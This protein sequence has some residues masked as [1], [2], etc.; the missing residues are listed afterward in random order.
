MYIR[1][2]RVADAAAIARVHV[3][4]WRTTYKDL[5]PED[6][7]ANLSYEQRERF[8]Q[9]IVSNADSSHRVY[10]AEDETGNLVGFASGGPERTDNKDYRGEIYAIY[11]LQEYHRQGI[12]RKLANALVKRLMQAGM[13]SLLVWVLAENRSREFYERLGGEP[14]FEKTTTIGD[15]RV[16]EIGYGWRDAGLLTGDKMQP[17]SQASDE[18]DRFRRHENNL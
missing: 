16:I 6:F 2:A 17:G 9:N 15:T 3:D 14:V 13:S 11:V 1:P 5:L 10:V 12:G 8:W 7:L 4:T 18:R